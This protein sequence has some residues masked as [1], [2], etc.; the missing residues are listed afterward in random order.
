MVLFAF[1]HSALA[2]PECKRFVLIAIRLYMNIIPL[3]VFVNAWHLM[4]HTQVTI[5][6]IYK[7][8]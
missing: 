4:H 2:R 7:P 6:M 5:P 1:V 3:S 8:S